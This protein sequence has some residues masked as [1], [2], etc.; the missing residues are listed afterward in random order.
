MVIAAPYPEGAITRLAEHL[1]ARGVSL[2]VYEPSRAFSAAAAALLPGRLR[3]PLQER[4]RLAGGARSTRTGVAPS[5]EVI[6]LSARLPG[7]DRVFP[8]PMDTVK[9]SFDRAVAKRLKSPVGT[10]IGMPGAALA[11]FSAAQDARKVLHA[12]DGHPEAL[13]TLLGDVYGRI[14]D[15][16]RVPERQVARIG[17]EL[18]LADLVL[19]PSRIAARQMVERGVEQ[20]SIVTVPYGVDTSRFRPAK[21]VPHGGSVKLVYVGQISYRKGI[22]FLLDA[23]RGQ[24]F[25]VELIGPVVA[26]ELLRDLPANVRHRATLPHGALSG[27]LGRSDALVL[28]SIEDSYGLVVLEGIAAGLPVV[29]TEQVGA[30]D[31]FDVGAPGEAV[32]AADAIGLRAALNRVRPLSWDAR[33]AN[34]ASLRAVQTWASYG[35]AVLRLLNDG[36]PK[37]EER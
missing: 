18:E 5:L 9:A 17:A 11:S 10:L 31:L 34:A 2:D 14:A 1:E 12:V 19:T 15:A 22:P 8:R 30:A 16:E 36:T 28:P 33:N 6:R 24:S 37:N 25:E 35:D 20:E 23:A 32:Q 4:L 29:V 3:K 21:E 7:M 26:P 27:V 13:N